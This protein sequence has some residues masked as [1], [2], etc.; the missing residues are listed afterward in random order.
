MTIIATGCS[1]VSRQPHTN[2]FAWQVDT[3]DD[4]KVLQYK[5]N[6]F[7]SLTI[8]QKKLIYYL[9][10]AAIA[11]RD[12]LFDQNFRYNLPIRRTLEA[13]YT[14]Y[15]GERSGAEW[16][17]FE[18][19]LKKV[20]FANGIHHHYSN[21]KFIP[22]FTTE[23]FDTL[24]NGTK[25]P[26]GM[27]LDT[28]KSIIFDANLYVKKVNQR[29]G[30]DM[31]AESA[32][33]FYSGVTQQEV[34]QY[35]D[36]MADPNDREPISYGLNTQLV[37]DNSGKITERVWKVDGM[38]GKALEQIV[39][40]I[41]KAATVAENDH[42]RRTILA[43]AEYY[44]TG[45]LRQFDVYNVLW[46]KDTV[47]QVDFVNGFIENYGDPMGYKATWESHVNFKDIEATKRTELISENA[48]W[49]EDHSPV[50]PRYKKAV[51]KGVS[52]KVITAA[53]VGGD[54]Y[55]ATPLGI[56]LPNADWIRRDHGSKSVTIANIS[57]AYDRSSVGSGFAEEF[58]SDPVE[59]ER[60]EKFL[61]LAGNL[62]TDLHECLGH[63]SG[64]L[65]PS[66]KGDELKNYGSPLEEARADL[67]ALY[68]IADP[69][70]VEL[71]IIPSVE[72]AWAE[73]YQTIL[74]GMMTQLTRIELGK[75]VEQAHMR[76]RKLIAEWAMELGAEDHVI[77]VVVDNGKR[78]IRINDYEKLR[79]IFGTMLAEI[80][81]VK[82]E[83]DFASGRELIEKYG[84]RI[85]P[86]LHKEV[87]A[88]YDALG[89]A[90]YSGFV[91]PRYVP[92]YGGDGDIKDVLIEY[93]A[94]YVEQMLEYSRD[95]SFL[96][97]EN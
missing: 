49:F 25:I 23:Y 4:I 63:G 12:I 80:Q 62:H 84:V 20:W 72:V 48:Q 44:K 66:T 67:F 90:P 22:G 60:R 81:R 16:E 86:E 42:Q 8:D 54:C 56:N 96:P 19:Y 38:Y 75:T 85:D 3:F 64:Q 33:N 65:A 27:P 46:V 57:E 50:D 10:Q 43:L 59:R 28:L 9:S 13:I 77:E 93:P 11:G 17:A 40:W 5:V 2:D 55:P 21:D 34:E 14:G 24:L 83:G 26:E 71:G 69:K 47:S 73:Y 92:V 91:N 78:Y 68:Y 61:P 41:E 74:N 18:T 89:I 1:Q 30:V 37:K 6:G 88:R 36:A 29:E 79:G 39:F 94:N 35:Y 53:M 7:D 32:C 87:R 51:V 70:M 31:V 15:N 97:N 76:N 95:H 45:D 82:S 58:I 52:A